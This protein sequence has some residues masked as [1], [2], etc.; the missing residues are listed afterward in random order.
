MLPHALPRL[1]SSQAHG[2]LEAIAQHC[3]SSV[4]QL[5]EQ[6][7]Y[8]VI[9]CTLYTGTTQ[10]TTEM[11][12]IERYL[13]EALKLACAGV[14]EIVMGLVREACQSDGW[15]L[16][17]TAVPAAVYDRTHAMLRVAVTMTMTAQGGGET[18]GPPSVEH[19]LAGVGCEVVVV[20]VV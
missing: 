5:L 17:D 18:G 1:V 6:H 16:S 19:F 11:A 4:R 8:E 9:A 13:P 3:G 15:S 2:A 14:R 12:F 20:Y 10:F 7:L